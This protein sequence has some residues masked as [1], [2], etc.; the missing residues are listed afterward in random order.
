MPR[1]DGSLRAPAPT[2]PGA[3]PAPL[4]VAGLTSDRVPG[5]A[6]PNQVVL[7]SAGLLGD[8]AVACQLWPRME[9]LA[10]G[11]AGFHAWQEEFLPPHWLWNRGRVLR[12]QAFMRPSVADLADYALMCWATCHAEARLPRPWPPAVVRARTALLEFETWLSGPDFGQDLA[13]LLQVHVSRVDLAWRCQQPPDQWVESLGIMAWAA[14]WLRT[15]RTRLAASPEAVCRPCEETQSESEGESPE[16]PPGT[17]TGT[18]NHRTDVCFCQYWCR[19]CASWICECHSCQCQRPVDRRPWRD[20]QV[21]LGDPLLWLFP[22]ARRHRRRWRPYS[23]TE[24]RRWYVATQR[25]R[26]N[27][28]CLLMLERAVRLLLAGCPGDDVPSSQDRLLQ[29]RS[30]PTLQLLGQISSD[31]GLLFQASWQ[32]E[33]DMPGLAEAASFP[34]GPHGLEPSF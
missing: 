25:S 6:A 30:V 15:L 26:T 13:T 12:H 29:L 22:A 28:M 20:Y 34:S 14:A 3:L 2:T 10:F 21:P 31:L 9:A 1:V 16:E 8:L 7:Q 11:W 17:A 19:A 18:C 32:Q 4:V 23:Q 5:P 27:R 24:E 33:P